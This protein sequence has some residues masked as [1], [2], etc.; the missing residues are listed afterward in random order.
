MKRYRYRLG[1]SGLIESPD[2][3]YGKISDF[4][5]ELEKMQRRHKKILAIKEGRSK[6][7][8]FKLESRIQEL[9]GK[10][11]SYED[12]RKYVM[13]DGLHFGPVIHDGPRIDKEGNLYLPHGPE[14]IGGRKPEY[15]GHHAFKLDPVYCVNCK[16]IKEAS[17]MVPLCIAQE[18]NN[19]VTG[20]LENPDCYEAN[21]NCNCRLFEAKDE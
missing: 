6:V 2:G 10:V 17:Y 7:E 19:Q 4:K 21:K 14:P 1:Y 5:E 18:V 11:K 20:V 3:T 9:E 16:H 13:S 12:G 15:I 8:I